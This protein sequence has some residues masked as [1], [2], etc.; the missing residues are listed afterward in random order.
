MLELALIFVLQTGAPT[1]EL[2]A[3]HAIS[4]TTWNTVYDPAYVRIPYP[5]GDLPRTRGVCTDVIIRALRSV[6]RDL[7][8]LVHEDIVRNRRSYP[9]ISRPDTNIDHRRCPA[10]KIFLR[11]HG[12]TL[13]TTAD[14]STFKQWKPGDIVFWKL[15]SGLDHVG[16]VTWPNVAGG[17]PLVVHNLGG[18]RH[19]DVL[20]SWKIVGHFRYPK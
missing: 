12:T 2:I 18:T 1:S 19:E 10:L 20:T 14:S 7:Q 16:I 11:R 17:P 8:R 13:T 6:G 15:D 5:N 9:H 4:Q 3:R